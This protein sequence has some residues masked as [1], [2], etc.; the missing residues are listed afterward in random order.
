MGPSLWYSPPMMSRLFTFIIF[1][2]ISLTTI[3]ASWAVNTNVPVVSVHVAELEEI[4]DIHTYPARVLAKNHATL[5]AEVD[6]LVSKIF[7]SIG[8]EVK[9]GDRLVQINRT[10]PVY[11]YAASYVV[12]P[13]NGVVSALNVREGTQV[14]KGKEI[15]S[16]TDPSNVRVHVEIASIDLE[17]IRPGIQGTFKISGRKES[18]PVKIIGVSPFV[19]SNTGTATCELAFIQEKAVVRPGVVGQVT[20]RANTHRG[21]IIPGNAIYYK[22]GS[23]YV[24]V[25]D[26]EQTVHKVRVELGRKQRGTVEVLKGIRSGDRI[27]EQSSNF[28]RDGQKVEVQAKETQST[29]PELDN[30]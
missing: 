19:K 14:Q 4:S 16:V 13:L 9:K 22:E 6:G 2:L 7:N 3:P 29:P 15:V 8:A 26:K 18:Y 5:F 17:T 27:V 21:I 28:L 24:R 1:I 11:Q 12:A 20:F 23:T 10:D 25:V 30:E